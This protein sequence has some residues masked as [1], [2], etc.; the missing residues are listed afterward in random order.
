VSARAGGAVQGASVVV[1]KISLKTGGKRCAVEH[2]GDPVRRVVDQ[3][4]GSAIAI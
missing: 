1:V 3:E 2:S 4:S